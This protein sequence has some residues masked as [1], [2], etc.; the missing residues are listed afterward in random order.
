VA[1]LDDQRTLPP[2]LMRPVG[3]RA[4]STRKNKAGTPAP[5]SRM[6]A[7]CR[8]LPSEQIEKQLMASTR[9]AG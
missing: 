2:A 8:A 1:R 9:K 7:A 5:C 4:T 6:A 3:G